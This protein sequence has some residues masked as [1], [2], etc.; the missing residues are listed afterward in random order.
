MGTSAIHRG[1]GLQEVGTSVAEVGTSVAEVGTSVAEV[2]TSVAEV[3]TSG[4][5]SPCGDLC[6]RFTTPQPIGLQRWGPLLQS[7]GSLQHT[8]LPP[9]GKAS[10]RRLCNTSGEGHL[11][12]QIQP[13]K[14]GPKM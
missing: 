11:V 14:V 3:G 7:C 6:A 5:H 10:G 9:S 12:Q 2:E 1:K 13:Y 4:T 8:R